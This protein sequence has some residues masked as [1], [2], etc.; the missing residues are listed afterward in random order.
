MTTLKKRVT[1]ILLMG[2]TGERFPSHHI[3]QCERLSGKKIY[4][5]TLER[6]LSTGAINEIILVTHPLIIEEVRKEVA[7]YSSVPIKVVE[8]G[9]S[10]QE[11]SY[12]GIK[13]AD[14]KTDYVVIHD[15]VRPLVSR[16]IIQDNIEKV[17]Q[18]GAVD[19]CIPTAD[20]LV[21]LKKAGETILDSIPDR[22]CYQR[23]QTPQ[24][25]EYSL[26][27]QAHERALQMGLKGI[28]DDCR[29][30]LEL[31]HPIHIVQGDEENIKITTELDLFLAEQILR[32]QRGRVES[33][34]GCKSLKGCRYIVVGGSEGI[35]KSLCN[36]LTREGAEALALSRHSAYSFD[37]RN[38]ALVQDSFEKIFAQYG[39]VDGLINSAGILT[40][41]GLS[42]LSFEEIR[43]MLEVNLHGV[44]YSCRSAKVKKGG[45]IVNIASSSFTRGRPYYAIYSCAKAAV[46]NFTQALAEEW[47]HLNVNALVPHRTNTRLRSKNFAEED[48]IQELLEPEEVA[49]A[50]ID[51]LKTEKLTGTFV[52]VRKR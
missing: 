46:V 17:L 2:G 13:A 3:K 20:T 21:K 30:V 15:A 44:I 47:P 36:L 10:R 28:S 11:S 43:E 48:N 41:K 39:E 50:I 51:I 9:G 16:R 42:S 26:I 38:P 19:T 25:F 18:Y 4:L 14:P 29:L 34:S 27:L 40:V 33:G 1:A 24:S 37:V 6:F 12:L 7:G 35:G 32:L 23:G 22:S 52:E 49:E 8:G 45:H 31:G 5:H